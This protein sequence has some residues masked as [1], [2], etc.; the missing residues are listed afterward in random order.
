MLL[1]QLW[2]CKQQG[3]VSWLSVRLQQPFYTMSMQPLHKRKAQ[4]SN[5]VKQ[6]PQ[7]PDVR[8]P[9]SATDHTRQ[10]P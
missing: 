6:V 4:H 10:M 5:T 9:G 8:E 7:G 2:K 1:V 3:R